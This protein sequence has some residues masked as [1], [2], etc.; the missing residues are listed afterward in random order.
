MNQDQAQGM[1]PGQARR[2][3][4]RPEAPVGA[5]HTGVVPAAVTPEDR[6]AVVPAGHRAE[7]PADRQAED[8]VTVEA[9][10]EKA[11]RLSF[12]RPVTRGRLTAP[13]FITEYLEILQAFS[14]PTERQ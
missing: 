12:L 6:Q 5:L 1:A 10:P 7:G 14:S 13:L 2:A 3:E 9:D 8:P 11:N 4:M